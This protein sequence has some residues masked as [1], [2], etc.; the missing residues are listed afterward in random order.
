[1]LVCTALYAQP[2]EMGLRI[3][4]GGLEAAYQHELYS[5]QFIEA[6]LGMDLGYNLNGRSVP[7]ITTGTAGGTAI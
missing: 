2:R 5:T 4:A 7:A 1:M 6:D 3:G